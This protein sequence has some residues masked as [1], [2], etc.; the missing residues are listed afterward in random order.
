MTT[1]RGG[2]LSLA[3]AVLLILG[4]TAWFKSEKQSLT[5]GFLSVVCLVLVAAVVLA[6]LGGQ[7]T[8]QRLSE[9]DPLSEDRLKIFAA[10][11]PTFKASPWLGYGLGAFRS[12]NGLSMNHENATTLAILGAAH[13]VYL[14][15]LLQE[16]A[17]GA[18]AMIGSVALVVMATI[19]GV[20]RRAGQQSLGLA[21]LGVTAVFAVHG[22][23]DFA[24]ETPSTAAFFSAIL[25]LGY[26]LAERPAGG[27]RS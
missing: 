16:G 4:L 8:A 2:L 9:T 7:Q 20:A 10:Y 23:V 11:W 26:G 1:S 17:P 24:L 21:C 25:G 13:N 18:A 27:R 3:A 5:G 14:Q 15:W 19:R 6:L 22:L 12:W